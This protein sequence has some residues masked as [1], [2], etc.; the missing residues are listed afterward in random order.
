MTWR[1]PHIA[2]RGRIG[3]FHPC[4]GAQV[5][6]GLRCVSVFDLELSWEL[7]G[8]IVEAHEDDPDRDFDGAFGRIMRPPGPDHEIVRAFG[9]YGRVAAP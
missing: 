9:H 5:I 6:E 8:V 4:P 2:E 3:M 1:E 7:A